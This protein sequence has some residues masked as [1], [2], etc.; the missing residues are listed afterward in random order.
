MQE[1]YIEINNL[2]V[3]NELSEF[4]TNELL[5]DTNISVENFWS[6]FEKTLDELAPKNR[7]LI[8]IR[9]NLQNKINDWHIKN[10]G[11]E[12]NLDEYKKFLLEIGYLKK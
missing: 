2:K 4:V 5:K 10:K 11:K 12:I 3:S 8:N 7:E 6:G 9:K 1:K